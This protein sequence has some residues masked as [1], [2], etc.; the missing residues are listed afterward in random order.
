MSNIIRVAVIDDHPLMRDGIV[1]TL[2]ADGDF[3][4]VAE[5][6]S[7]AK[8]SEIAA[9]FQP[10]VMLLDISMPGGGFSV[11][12]DIQKKYQC[13]KIVVLTVSESEKNVQ[14]ALEAGAYGYILK[15]IGGEELRSAVKLVH[16]GKKYFSPE[17]VSIVINQQDNNQISDLNVRESEILELISSGMTNREIGVQLKLAEKS[18]KYYLTTI[19]RKLGVRNRVEAAMLFNSERS[20]AS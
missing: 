9:K 5:G 7:A 16:S 2:A 19:F 1:H 11:A 3:D 12:K 15:G 18:V 13:I 8:A 14:A 4:I 6:D 17:L 20:A 10:D